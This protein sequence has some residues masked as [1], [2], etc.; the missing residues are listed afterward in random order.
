MTADREGADTEARTGE[1]VVQGKS[2]PVKRQD[3]PAIVECFKT[4]DSVNLVKSADV[5]QVLL[6]L[7]QHVPDGHLHT[8]TERRM[9]NTDAVGPAGVD[10][11]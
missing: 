9:C 2:Y 4:Y 5:G 7:Q 1:I 6:C 11:T 8:K 10:S 3:L